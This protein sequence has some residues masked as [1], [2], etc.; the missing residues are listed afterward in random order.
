MPLHGRYDPPQQSFPAAA[1]R[2]PHNGHLPVPAC[3][4]GPKLQALLIPGADE[5]PADFSLPSMA[6]MSHDHT[7]SASDT[8]SG[9][10]QSP[11]PL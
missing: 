6:E 3:V 8:G 5:I 7:G 4:P 1:H 10:L 11:H 9:V 2:Y